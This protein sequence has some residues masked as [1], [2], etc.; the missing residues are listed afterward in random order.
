VVEQFG[1]VV[2]EA[3][4]CGAAALVSDSGSLPW[5]GG[6][7]AVVVGQDDV[8]GLVAAIRG[9][10]DDPSEVARLRKLGPL[11]AERFSWSSIA[12][13]QAELYRA[14]LRDATGPVAATAGVEP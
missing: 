12:G 1:R 11:S 2:V 9:L 7:A 14:V 8:E 13:R 10:R 3:E 5:V 4:A 6:D